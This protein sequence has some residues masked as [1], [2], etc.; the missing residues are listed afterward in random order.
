V[1]RAKAPRPPLDEALARQAAHAVRNRLSSIGV[2]AH[3]IC[4]DGRTDPDLASVLR[5]SLARLALDAELL[6]DLAQLSAEYPEASAPLIDLLLEAIRPL[7]W[8]GEAGGTRVTLALPPQLEA[9]FLRPREVVV[10]ARRLIAAVVGPPTPPAVELV[11]RGDAGCLTMFARPTGTEMRADDLVE[12]V[13][14]EHAD[15][16]DLDLAVLRWALSRPGLEVRILVAPDRSA[17]AAELVG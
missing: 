5:G 7:E 3:L 9:E 17:A 14:A 2:L 13:P 11:C 15:P 6:V 12:F 10:A 4:E 1:Q 16:A 8:L